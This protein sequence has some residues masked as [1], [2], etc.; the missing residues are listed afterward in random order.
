MFDYRTQSITEPNWCSIG[1][2]YRTFDWIRRENVADGK[3][4]AACLPNASGAGKARSEASETRFRR[5][6]NTLQ[7]LEK[8]TSDVRESRARR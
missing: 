8:R 6:E 7:M 1:F 5:Q 3:I 2:D 4:S